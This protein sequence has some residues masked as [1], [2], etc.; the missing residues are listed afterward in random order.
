MLKGKVFRR[1]MLT[2]RRFK[3]IASFMTSYGIYSY[4]P[5][6]AAYT[7]PTAPILTACIAAFYGMFS[8][9]ES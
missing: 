5:Y 4:L 1:K 9:A 3:G 6:I 7:G 8:F 2:P